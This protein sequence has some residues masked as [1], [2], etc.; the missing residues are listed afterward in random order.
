MNRQITKSDWENW[1]SSP[2]AI[3]FREMFRNNAND[4]AN[5]IMIMEKAR[6]GL[7]MAHDIGRY[8]I[9]MDISNMTYEIFNTLRNEQEWIPV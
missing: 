1:W 6:D 4:L 3:E 2:V 8:R 5:N 9:M 7:S